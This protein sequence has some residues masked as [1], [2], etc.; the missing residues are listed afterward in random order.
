M[1][2]SRIIGGFLG[3]FQGVVGYFGSSFAAEAET[4]PADLRSIP[5][6]R[7]WDDDKRRD[8]AVRILSKCFAQAH[9]DVHPIADAEQIYPFQ[10]ATRKFY[11]QGRLNRFHRVDFVHIAE[12]ERREIYR[13]IVDYFDLSE[14]RF[15]YPR[16]MKVTKYSAPNTAPRGDSIGR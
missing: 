8:R 13:S 4:L 11:V 15:H 10:A 1:K 14:E 7:S 5:R 12:D 6:E 3:K 2:F 9:F 16:V